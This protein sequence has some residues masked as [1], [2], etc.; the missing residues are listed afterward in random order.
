[1][2][3]RILAWMENHL[4]LTLI[5]FLII[6]GFMSGLTGEMHHI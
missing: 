3:N 5:I 4:L 2:L 6:M 1:M